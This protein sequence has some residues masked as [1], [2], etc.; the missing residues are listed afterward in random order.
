MGEVAFHE[1]DYS[2]AIHYARR[3]IRNNPGAAGAMD[4][5]GRAYEKLSQFQKCAEEYQKAIALQP[6]YFYFYIQAARCYRKSGLLDLAIAILLKAADHSSGEA[7]L[8]KELAV[9]YKI[10]GAFEDAGAAW[11]NYLKLKPTAADR[12][13]IRKKIQ[14]LEK[15]IGK[16]VPG[17]PVH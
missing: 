10:R 5:A 16:K 2:K 4:L 3:E 13:E 6:N 17:C 12:G 15:Q 14:A 1:R 9:I 11:C 7:E 8:Y